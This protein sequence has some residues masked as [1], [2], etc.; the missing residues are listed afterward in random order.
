MKPLIHG[1]ALAL[2]SAAVASCGGGDEKKEEKAQFDVS[3][4]SVLS[5]DGGSPP[6]T[7]GAS[8]A[9]D[10]SAPP[11]GCLA[12]AM[13]PCACTSGGMGM[14][15]CGADG[16]FG[17]CACAAPAGDGGNAT[18]DVT[19]PPPGPTP[20]GSCTGDTDCAEGLVCFRSGSDTPSTRTPGF[21]TVGGCQASDGPACAQPATGSVQA[22]CST[23]ADF[24]TLDCADN[25]DC[26]DEMECMMVP[27]ALQRCNYPVETSP[28]YGPCT[29]DNDCAQGTACN[30]F[31]MHC[32]QPCVDETNCT[33]PFDGTATA[34]CSP[35]AG[36]C[37]LDCSGDAECP[38]GMTCTP[39]PGGGQRCSG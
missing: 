34:D 22:E 5:N 20:F 1:C 15:V 33:A 25:D 14:R 36:L 23:F 17:A 18:P 38:A 32:A 30:M 8:G 29:N 21:C 27:P 2:V 28:A 26:P 24:C 35:T 4:G 13:E 31:V 3:D 19:P 7:G 39:Q 6:S 12:G 16:T 11:S 9:G 37:F 10:S